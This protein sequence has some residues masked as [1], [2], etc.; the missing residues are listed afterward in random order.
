MMV[1]TIY[2]ATLESLAKQGNAEAALALTL[3]ENI[4]A[5]G[6]RNNVRE[7]CSELTDADEALADALSVNGDRWS[8]ATDTHIERARASIRNALVQFADR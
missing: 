5:E 7:I 8:K 6:L 4:G 3:G 2:R 1:L